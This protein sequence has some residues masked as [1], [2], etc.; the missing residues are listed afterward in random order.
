MLKGTKYENIKV[1]GGIIVHLTAEG[2]MTEYRIPKSFSDTVLTMPPLPRI[3]E[4]MAKKYSDIAREEKR[5][6][7]LKKFLS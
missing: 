3:K 2:V 7:D 1:L 6:D 4:V 5:K